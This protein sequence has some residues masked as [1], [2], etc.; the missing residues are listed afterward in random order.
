[1]ANSGRALKVKVVPRWKFLKGFWATLA[2]YAFARYHM[3]LRWAFNIE[4]ED[5]AKN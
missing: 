2:L 3:P 1:M 5:A 4:T